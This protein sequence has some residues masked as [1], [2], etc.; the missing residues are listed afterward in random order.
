MKLEVLSA[1]WCPLARDFTGFYADVAGC[2]TVSRMESARRGDLLSWGAS[3]HRLSGAVRADQ[4]VR[5]R[6]GSYA[7]AEQWREARL[8]EQHRTRAAAAQQAAR[9]RLV[10]CHVTAAALHRLPLFDGPSGRVHVMSRS[11]GRNP[12]TAPVIRH[13]ENWDGETIDIDGLRATSL[14]RTVFDVART[15]SSATAIGCMDA[16]VR[17]IVHGRGDGQPDAEAAGRFLE[18]VGVFIG[19]HRGARGVTQAR[20]VLDA[21]DWRAESVGESVSRLY[22]A[23]L[24]FEEV[25]LQVEVPLPEGRIARVDFEVD[26]VLGEFDGMQKYFDRTVRADRSP[27]QVLEA[28]KRREDAIRAATGKRLV[29]WTMSDI[30]SRSRFA[31]FLTAADLHPRSKGHQTAERT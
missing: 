4:L 3:D 24:G 5:V 22:L 28:E 29:R 25:D 19:A 6:H 9:T 14:E 21:A 16:A 27:A 30:S 31:A 8:A 23:E 15:A 10:F 17:R 13:R 2:G 1:V 7:D 18:S 11:R 12:S 20:R 26:G